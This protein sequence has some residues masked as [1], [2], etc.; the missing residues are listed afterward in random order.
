MLK[1]FLQK[2]NKQQGSATVEAVV[3]FTGFI[4]AIFTILSLVNLCRAQM[5]ISNAMDNAAKELS[6]YAY[7]YKM[8]GLQRFKRELDKTASVGK[9]D[10]NGVIGAV[11][12]FYTSVVDAA[13]D[14]VE[15]GTNIAEATKEGTLQWSDVESALNGISANADNVNFN[16][17]AMMT[18]FEDIGDNPMAYMKSLVAIAGSGGME[19]VTS[20][21]IAAPLAKMFVRQQFGGKE[22]ANDRLKALGVKDGLDGINFKM[23][24]MFTSTNPEDICL[25]AFYEV[26]LLQLFDREVLSAKLSKVSRCRAWLAG[27]D[28][29]EIVD[30]TKPATESSGGEGGNS[31]EG[32]ATDATNP[33]GTPAESTPEG[34]TDATTPEESTEPTETTAPP[35]DTSGSI[36]HQ[37]DEFYEGSARDIGFWDEF[38]D[39]YQL[40]KDHGNF[41][42]GV[43]DEGKPTNVAYTVSHAT[44]ADDINFHYLLEY[45]ELASDMKYNKE[46]KFTTTDKPAYAVHVI[47]V[48]ENISAEE[49]EKIRTKAEKELQEFQDIYNEWYRNA[50]EEQKKELEEQYAMVGMQIEI[51]EAGGNYDYGSGG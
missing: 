18:K 36:W 44:S 21:L 29:Q 4:L 49:K 33:D 13:N 14:S 19:L 42:Y 17:D 47:Y 32:G 2:V 23:S 26:E 20:H 9:E 6:Q 8:S 38:Q 39:D 16:L 40:G 35:V 41:C 34:T 31:G 51:R 30:P 3:A 50:T 11:D 27:D 46:H 28:F 25:V 10:V 7:F 22:H 15:A 24:T 5:L 43:D 45:Q 1:K 37:E 48:P 12:E